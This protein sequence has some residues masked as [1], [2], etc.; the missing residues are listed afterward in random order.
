MAVVY[1]AKDLRHFRDVAIKIFRRE[2]N[3]PDEGSERFLQEIKIAAR[4][5]HPNILPLH[6]S[7]DDHGL[8]FYVMPYVPGESLRQ[9]LEREGALPLADALT[10]ATDIANALGYAHSHGVIH[11]DIKP[12]NILFIAG[13]AV[14]ADFGIARAISAGGWDEWKLAGPAGTPAYMSPEQGRG[15]S[16]VDG[17]SDLYSLG[18]VLYEMLTGAPPFRG[19][20]PEELVA[21]HQAVEPEPVNNL[22]PTIPRDV[23]LAVGRALAKHPADRYQTALQLA[24]AL[25]RLRASTGAEHE[26]RITPVEPIAAAKR[27]PALAHWVRRWGGPSFIAAGLAAAVVWTTGAVKTSRLDSNLLMIGPLVHRDSVPPEL[28]G[29][30]CSRL[31]SHAISRWEDV[32]AAD[33]RWTDDQIARLGHRPSLNDLLEVA[34]DGGAGRLL[35]G[36][37]WTGAGDSVKVRVVMYDVRRGSRVLREHTVAIAP[38]LADIN[39]RFAELADSLVLAR[40]QSPMALSGIMGTS[41]SAA[42][43]QY[44]SGHA[45]LAQW[46]LEKARQH[47]TGAI[48]LDPNYQLAYLWRAQTRSWQGE[49]IAQWRDDARRGIEDPA[50]LTQSEREWGRAL[51]ALGE[52]RFPDACQ[53]FNEMLR[54]DSLDFRGWY[55]RGDCRAR[56]PAVIRDDNSPSKFAFRASYAAA[57]AD[58]TRALTLIPS[59]N[60]AFR[61]AAFDRLRGVLF[62]ENRLLRPGRLL[63]ADSV[64]FAA[65]PEIAGDT[66]AFVPWTMEQIS[67]RPADLYPTRRAA[68][69]RNLK[70]LDRIVSVWVR[71]FPRSA[72][73]QKARALTWE[74]IGQ[75]DGAETPNSALSAIRTARSLSRDSIESVELRVIQFR[76]L[77]K[78]EQFE[79]ARRL[80]DSL[81]AEVQSDPTQ[82]QEVAGMALLLGRPAL[83][84]DL[85]RPETNEFTTAFGEVVPTAIPLRESALRLKAFAAVGG[86]RDSV[87]YWFTRTQREIRSYGEPGVRKK[88][89]EALIDLA[90]L[91]LPMGWG[92]AYFQPNLPPAI[93]AMAFRLAALEDQKDSAL[94]AQ[95][96]SVRAWFRLVDRGIDDAPWMFP[97]EFSV[98]TNTIRV[99]EGD[100]AGAINTLDHQLNSL[101]MLHNDFLA[102]MPPAGTLVRLMLLRMEIAEAHGDLATA[103]RWAGPAATLWAEAEP[104][105]Q[106]LLAD[107]R[108]LA[109]Q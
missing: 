16:R 86:P 108:R 92:D 62:A 53:L 58:Y 98:L 85:L 30:Q 22:R 9:R 14:V 63:G 87:D 55:G 97:P 52:A 32:R 2:G 61:G 24:E 28:D 91:H 8:L 21:Q 100:T 102:E 44:D 65:F 33:S 56:D 67:S 101:R 43:E 78:S 94:Q 66:L 41:V 106:P 15:G 19:N 81:F 20:T 17:R 84:G 36:E 107:A 79:A 99:R 7:G 71:E 90:T 57:I 93:P 95:K 49:R 42:W 27:P 23:Q 70:T 54:R 69:S 74:L 51:V 76:L 1:F 6:D 38:G 80:A 31:L 59:S 88:M 47:F 10:I 60:H 48:S 35:S 25:A 29:Q 68:V 83:A 13:N 75:L 12:E 64:R 3:E 34:R 82:F 11:R 77:F 5:S 72:S 46:D 50:R 73:A 103:K 109:Q 26:Q 105:L 40:A 37:V 45:A 89:R 39:A 96:D 104:G 4:L 18:C